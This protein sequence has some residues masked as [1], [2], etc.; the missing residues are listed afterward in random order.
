MSLEIEVTPQAIAKLAE[1]GTDKKG[2]YVRVSAQQTC[3]CGRIG[4]RMAWEDAVA[5]GDEQLHAAGITLVVDADSR[6][7]IEGG[8]LDYEAD[9]MQEGF[10]LTNP[11]AQSGCSCGSH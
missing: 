6:P 8:I 3:G 9:P 1:L 4:Y 7:F 2:D 10:V 11:H 5:E